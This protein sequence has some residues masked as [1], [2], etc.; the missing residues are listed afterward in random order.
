MVKVKTSI[1]I[2]KEIKKWIEEQIAE[3][4]FASTSH[5]IEFIVGS[6]IKKENMRDNPTTKTERVHK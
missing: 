3:R 4:R 5:A 2:N 1:S 6:F